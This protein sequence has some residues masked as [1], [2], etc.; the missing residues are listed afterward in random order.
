MSRVRR[1][2]S[3]RT[4]AAPPPS[5]AIVLPAPIWA[6]DTTPEAIAAALEQSNRSVTWGP[7]GPRGIL[8]TVMIPVGLPEAPKEIQ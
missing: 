7:C 3:H 5:R 2:R 8:P 6:V 1:R 4:T